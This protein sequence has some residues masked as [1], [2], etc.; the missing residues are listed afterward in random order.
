M[1]SNNAWTSTRELQ[2]LKADNLDL[3]FPYDTDGEYGIPRIAPEFHI[4]ENGLIGFNYA[5]SST[6]YKKGVHCFLHDYQ[7]ESVWKC[8]QKYLERLMKFD[9]FFTPDF[10]LYTNMSHAQRIW[11]TYRS[12]LIGS[13]Y[14]SQGMLVIP[15]VTWNEPDTFDY[16]FD[17]IM[18][19]STV[20]VSTQGVHKRDD[21]MRIYRRGI[22]ELTERKHP[23]IYLV[24]GKFADAD[25]GDAEVVSYENEYIREL[26][27]AARKQEKELEK[28]LL[29]VA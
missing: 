7:F 4:P 20:A 3:Y 13:F 16:C 5:R 27:K 28:T 9:C 6:N 22:H 25:Y 15:T 2:G 17:G 19:E 10:S 26:K 8:P 1:Q 11:N 29:G 24:Y 18:P 23:S 12:R 14:Q 21:L